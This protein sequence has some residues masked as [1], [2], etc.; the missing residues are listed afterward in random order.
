MRSLHQ[1]LSEFVA[2]AV[3]GLS[4]W[5]AEQEVRDSSPGL[6]ATISEIGYL[7]LP[8]RDMAERSLKRHKSLK[9][10]TNLS[11]CNISFDHMTLTY[12]QKNFNMTPNFFY[13]KRSYH[14][15]HV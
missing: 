12:F 14:I 15:W 1:D 2:V 13:C 3:E 4:S 10:L 9:Q 6:T 7:L 8:C 5:L 11:E